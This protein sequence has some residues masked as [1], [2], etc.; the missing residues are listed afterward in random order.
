MFS[1][2]KNL[3]WFFRL[4]RK[5][6]LTG[7]ILLILVGIAELLPPRLLGNAIDEI[8]RGS[9]TGTSL[10]RYILLILGTV[11]IIYLVTYVWMHKLFGGANLV[12]RLLRSRFMDHLLRMTPPF[13]R[14]T[15][16]EI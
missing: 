13:L 9:I 7:V 1:V 8:V 4:E 3:A 2:L 5:R 16:Q 6:Y 15:E 11:I 12:E 14:K 10:T